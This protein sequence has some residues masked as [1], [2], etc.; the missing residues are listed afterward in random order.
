MLNR[1]ALETATYVR[2]SSK[3]FG[4]FL[5]AGVNSARHAKVVRAEFRNNR[6][7]GQLQ[8]IISQVP[9]ISKVDMNAVSAD[10]AVM[11]VF[12]NGSDAVIRKLMLSRGVKLQET[13]KYWTVSM[14]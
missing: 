7:W 8:D 6:E 14:R 9:G 13:G 10:Y 1:A 5:D 11:T 12:F 4:A 2:D 3:N